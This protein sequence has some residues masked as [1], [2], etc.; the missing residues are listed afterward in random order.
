MASSRARKGDEVSSS[1]NQDLCRIALEDTRAFASFLAE[2]AGD[3]TIL[4]DAE[5]RIIWLSRGAGKLLGQTL[6]E[7]AG[8]RLGD[9]T[10]DPGAVKDLQKRAW[11][12]SGVV[13]GRIT[14]RNREG[15]EQS[16]RVRVSR[17]ENRRGQAVGL[18]WV[19]R[20]AAAEAR[21]EK[22][23]IR[24]DRLTELG[25]MTSGIIHEIN[26]PVAVI[27]EVVGWAEVVLSEAKGMAAEDREELAQAIGHIVEQ[28]KR[29]RE[30]TRQ[31]LDFV[32]SSEPQR[33][34]VDV[35]ELLQ[36]TVRFLA[37]QV[38][39]TDIQVALDLQDA[40]L[41]ALSDPGQMSQILVNLMTNA[42]HAVKE[43]KSPGGRVR[44]TARRDGA[45]VEIV[46][47]DNGTGIPEG[48]RDRIFELFYTTKPSGEGTGLGLP[49][50]LKLV[51]GMDGTLE[52][53]TQEGVGTRFVVRIPSA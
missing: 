18:L 2:R 37:P 12:A 32:R 14:L 53:T 20:E 50:S 3:A 30:L 35:H 21:L 42:V 17:L 15:A 8:E 39:H 28:V 48:V 45:F 26:N 11:E 24:V 25:R 10:S 44:V 7:V 5:V 19:G 41:Q 43:K 4:T 52:F 33:T 49:I 13:L 36:K 51:Q 38:K 1:W 31:A 9:L 29:C 40:P 23:L 27:G 22:E 34:S 47:E 46:V 16:L 6:E